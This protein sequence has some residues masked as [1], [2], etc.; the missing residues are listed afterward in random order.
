[1][2]T[3][4]NI[5]GEVEQMAAEKPT[6]AELH[7]AATEEPTTG[8]TGV[9]P[10]GVTTLPPVADGT[11]AAGKKRHYLDFDFCGMKLACFGGKGLE[12]KFIGKKVNPNTP[13]NLNQIFEIKVRRPSAIVGSV[14]EATEN[15]ELLFRLESHVNFG[16]TKHMAVSCLH[17]LLDSRIKSSR[18]RHAAEKR[19]RKAKAAQSGELAK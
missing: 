14:A 16:Y 3:K 1:M 17:K 8:A 9:S 4:R 2:N 13:D 18:R 6:D 12:M 19:K 7:E 15:G 5:I 10:V 11:P